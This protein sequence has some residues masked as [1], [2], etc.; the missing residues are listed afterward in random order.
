[1]GGFSF[2]VVIPP[3][4]WVVKFDNTFWGPDPNTAW[5]VSAWVEDGSPAGSIKVST[6]GTWNEGYRPTK[7]RITGVVSFANSLS[8]RSTSGSSIGTESNG[9]VVEIDLTFGSFNIGDM[10]LYGMSS[11]TNIEFLEA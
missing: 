6:L 5:N 10:L 8:V 9:A 7:A 4:L 2:A 1:M 3:P 11:I